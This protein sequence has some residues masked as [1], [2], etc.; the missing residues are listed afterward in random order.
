[1]KTDFIPGTVFRGN[2][3]GVLFEIVKVEKNNATI[4]CLNNGKFF[5]YGVRALEHC[6]ITILGGADDGKE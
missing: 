1:M 4:K 2:V 3:N 5:V 6:D